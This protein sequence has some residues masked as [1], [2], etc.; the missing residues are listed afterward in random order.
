[1]P[2]VVDREARRRQVAEAVWQVVRAHGPGG[3]TMRRVADAAGM[4]IG[5][6]QHY[7]S[8]K[9]EMERFALE[10]M[11]AAAQERMRDRLE[12]VELPSSARATIRLVLIESTI[13]ADDERI[14]QYQV[15]LSYSLN[16]LRD[17]R[18]ARELR[19]SAEELREFLA[20]QLRQ[21]QE[22]GELTA[23]V[24][25]EDE[26]VLLACFADGCAQQILLGQLDSARAVRTLDRLLDRLFCP[27]KRNPAEVRRA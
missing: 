16:A 8:S 22:L 7:F 19:A 20:G 4:S 17:E 2:K 14:A 18:Q 10:C 15:L 21:A 23:G 5:L 1:M 13:P 12:T 27:D 25:P 9:E 26:A 11:L 6:V 3:A 24:I